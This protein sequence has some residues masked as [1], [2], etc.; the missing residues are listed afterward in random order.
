M[1]SNTKNKE[2][3]ILFEMLIST[4]Q[5]LPFDT[6]LLFVINRFKNAHPFM[7]QD[8]GIRFCNMRISL[9]IQFRTFVN[10]LD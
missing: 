10:F 5:L 2:Q 7:T 6:R 1:I 8:Y 4:R 9:E 3:L